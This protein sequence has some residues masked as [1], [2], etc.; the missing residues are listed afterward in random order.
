MRQV[1]TD[2][3]ELD[4]GLIRELEIEPRQSNSELARKL[5]TSPSTIGRRLRWLI[6]YRVIRISAIGDPIALGFTTR[7]MIA[8]NVE[9][10]AGDRVAEEVARLPNIRSVIM[11]TGRYDILTWV[12]LKSPE[13]LLD[14]MTN[15]LS[16]ITGITHT[17]IMIH[18]KLYMIIYGFFVRNNYAPQKP[19]TTYK[20]D[21]LD[22]DLI[23]AL[24]DDGM[25]SNT[26]LVN[27]LGI[28]WP[29]V[30]S[31]LQRLVQEGIVSFA[32]ITNMLALGY[33]T[34][35]IALLKVKF[36]ELEDVAKKLSELKP[37]YHLVGSAGS[38][39][40]IALMFFNDVHHMSE[41]V[42]KELGNISGVM[43]YETMVGLRLVKFT[44][45]SLTNSRQASR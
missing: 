39:Q 33:T 41:F 19:K 1:K 13:D 10:G 26:G 20:L 15:R 17:D 45:R 27:K 29:T 3:D 4:R 43:S 12:Y 40:L 37:I 42:R 25:L 30:Q 11:T 8:I 23:M 38:Y 36:N 18:L 32:T 2:L 14:F 5:D 28:S 16:T 35:A 44:T 7:A 24:E 31:R 34:I 6:N 9:S 22:R 21:S